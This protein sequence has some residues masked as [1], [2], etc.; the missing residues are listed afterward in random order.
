MSHHYECLTQIVDGTPQEV[1]DFA[2][3]YRVEVAGRLVS[4][5]DFRSTHQCPCH[6]DPLLLTP[7]QFI[8]PVSE[9]VL[10]PD[11]LDD[12]DHPGGVGLPSCQIQRQCEVLLSRQGWDE[13][14]R[15]EDE[16]D[17]VASQESEVS[18]GEVTEFNVADVDGARGQVVKSRRAVHERR[19]A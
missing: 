11:R 17:L 9:A 1:E 16:P 3:S 6:C 15:L 10:K 14:E 19:L 18:F 7:G 2:S 4:K 12:V 13:V 5:D 8:W